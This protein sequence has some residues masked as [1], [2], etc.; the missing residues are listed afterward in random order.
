V[1]AN[2]PCPD[3]LSL[4]EDDRAPRNVLTF[5]RRV[6]APAY[7]AADWRDPGG[8]GAWTWH[9]LR[10]VLCTTALFTWKLDATDVS[11][12][13]GHANVRTTLDMSVRYHRRHPRPR[14][15]SHRMIQLRKSA[16]FD[17]EVRRPRRGHMGRP[18]VHDLRR[19]ARMNRLRGTDGFTDRRHT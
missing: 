15:H 14:P 8:N 17:I 5:A 1:T 13:A 12:I 4:V 3:G 7:L 19:R 9:S 2:L 11:A 10:H 18:T 6:L 16:G